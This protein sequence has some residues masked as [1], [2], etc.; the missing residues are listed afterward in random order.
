[1][2]FTGK[3]AGLPA[4]AHQGVAGIEYLHQ[5][6]LSAYFIHGIGFKGIAAEFIEGVLGAEKT[7]L[8][9]N[10]PDAFFE[11]ETAGNKLSQE[12][13]HNFSTGGQDLLGDNDIKRSNFLQLQGTLDSAVIGE[14][15][16]VNTLFLTG[17]DNLVQGSI[18]VHRISRMDMKIGFQQ[19]NTP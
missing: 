5:V 16:T 19:I 12:H 1:M 2:V 18:A 15:N 6:D 8:L 17:M 3:L 9:F 7:A 4:T 11:R 10:A 14:S 13:P